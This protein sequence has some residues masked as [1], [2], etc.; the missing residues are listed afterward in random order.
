MPTFSHGTE[1]PLLFKLWSIGV[2]LLVGGNSVSWNIGLQAGSLGFSINTTLASTGF[3]SMALCISEILSGLPF[4]GGAFGMVRCTVGFFPGFIVGCT[5]VCYYIITASLTV[6]ALCPMIASSLHLTGGLAN[7]IIAL[8]FYCS[9]FLLMIQRRSSGL[10]WNFTKAL[11]LISVLLLLIYFVG[12]LGSSR[13]YRTKETSVSHKNVTL[14]LQTITYFQASTWLYTGIE[15]LSFVCNMISIPKEVIAKGFMASLGTIFIL[16]VLVICATLYIFQDSDELA[17]VSYPLNKGFSRFF[18]C[19]EEHATLLSIPATFATA[20]GF[21]FAYGKLLNSLAESGL[22]PSFLAQ[23]TQAGSPYGSIVTGSFISYCIYLIL[24]FLPNIAPAFGNLCFLGA[25][26]TYCSYCVSYI[27]I[28]KEFGKSINFSFKS[29]LH[30]FGALYAICVFAYGIVSI[31]MSKENPGM[32]YLLLAVLWICS[33]LY[34]FMVARH[35]QRF[36][37]EEQRSVYEGRTVSRPKIHRLFTFKL[38]MNSNITGKQKRI[39]RINPLQVNVSQ[40]VRPEERAAPRAHNTAQNHN[41]K[42]V[43]EILLHPDEVVNLRNKALAAFCAENVDFCV[44][45]LSYREKCHVILKQGTL[46]D[47]V[48][49]LHGTFQ[50]VVRTYIVETSSHEVN[51]SSAQKSNILK[52][53]SFQV[54]SSLHPLKIATIFDA[55][56]AEIEYVL[57]ANLLP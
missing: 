41:Q 2:V 44:A 6:Y 11:A 28:K 46:Q 43:H 49:F 39:L 25:Y 12:S 47:N 40:K 20:F 19:T 34:Y 38:S 27:A 13:V 4:S 26:I 14:Q 29:P 22:L 31:C 16:N 32:T 36:S 24:E 45:V 30:I 53:Q 1:L 8:L 9:V 50:S 52:Y 35:C 5:E 10:F 21:I 57:A 51:I 17:L 15:C 3:A 37:A 54:Y 33:S 55:A 42:T 48:Q 18:S 23:C 56:F 7:A